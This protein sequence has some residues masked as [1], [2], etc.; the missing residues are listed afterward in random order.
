[1]DSEHSALWSLIRACGTENIDEV[2]ITASGGPFRNTPAEELEKVTA[3]DAVKHP[4][5]KMGPKISI[6]SST[7]ANKGLEVIEASRLF[8]LEPDRIRVVIHPQSVVHSLVRLRNGAVYAYMSQPDMRL[9][10]HEALFYPDCRPCP[11]A[12]LDFS[13]L[14]LDFSLP[15]TRRFPML[16]LAYRSLEAGGLYTAAY[17]AANEALVEAFAA[18]S[19]K[20]TDFGPLMEQVLGKDFS[21]KGNIENRAALDAVWEADRRAREAVRKLLASQ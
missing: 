5:W 15:D 9:P 4:T 8:S 3:K 7:L 11:F 21:Y 10:I 17:N 19:I 18:G 16:A 14:H 6:D 12:K 2:L 13:D 20:F 1:V